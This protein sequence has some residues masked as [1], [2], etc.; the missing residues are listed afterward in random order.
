MV[1][2]TV[3][4]SATDRT[5]LLSCLRLACAGSDILLIEDAVYAAVTGTQYSHMV[6]NALETHQMYVLEADLE[7]RGF[8]ASQLIDGIK[9]VDYKGFVALAVANDTIHSWL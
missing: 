7:C 3:N 8:N 1:L 4:K 2:H 5:S 9:T 6:E